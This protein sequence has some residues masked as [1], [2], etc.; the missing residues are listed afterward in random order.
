[1]LHVTL[2]NLLAHKFRSIALVLTVVL[3]VSFVSGTYVLTDTITKVFDDL[4]SEAYAS[5]DLTVRSKSD[6][7]TDRA[8]EPVPE[9]LL[10]TV[11][12]VDGVAAAQGSVFSLRLDIIDAGG[13]HVGNPMAPSFGGGCRPT[14]IRCRRTRSRRAPARRCD[15]GGARRAVVRRRP[16]SRSVIR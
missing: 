12:S 5:V 3:G 10:A 1:M 13:D 8:H 4:F 2:K 11:R 16:L 7:G 15:R 6:L 9:S 14:R